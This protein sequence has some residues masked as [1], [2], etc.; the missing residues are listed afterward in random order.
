[1]TP[2][3]SRWGLTISGFYYIAMHRVTGRIE[4]LYYDPGS[5]PY[6]QLSMRPDNNIDERLPPGSKTKNE[7]DYADQSDMLQKQ[8]LSMEV[9]KW[10]PAFEI[11]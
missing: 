10:W 2:S 3:P 5:Q 4:G 8:D 9:K 1:M 6:Q 7:T 11:R